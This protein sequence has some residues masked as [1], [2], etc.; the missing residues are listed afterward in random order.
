M[1]VVTYLHRYAGVFKKENPVIAV[2]F[3]GRVT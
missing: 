2:V 1:P 3:G